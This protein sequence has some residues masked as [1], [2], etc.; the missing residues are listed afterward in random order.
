M[1]VCV[2]VDRGSG[3]VTSVR[4]GVAWRSVVTGVWRVAC[5]LCDEACDQQEVGGERRPL[6]RKVYGVVR[7]IVAILGCGLKIYDTLICTAAS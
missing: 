7:C 3:V 6:E 5:G 2:C 1:C 4:C